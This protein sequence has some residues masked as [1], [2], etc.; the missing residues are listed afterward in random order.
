MS[1]HG[2]EGGGHHEEPKK[3]SSGGFWREFFDSTI[4]QPIN[5]LRA[6]NSPEQFIETMS[7]FASIIGDFLGAAIWG[8]KGGGGGAKKSGGHGHH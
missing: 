2:P 1:G 3:K 4:M 7:G 8:G 5:Q 6:I